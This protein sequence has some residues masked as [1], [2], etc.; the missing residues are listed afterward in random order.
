MTHE[1][2]DEGAE[3]DGGEDE[4]DVN[5]IEYDFINKVVRLKKKVSA[6]KRITS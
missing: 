1:D 2:S 4:I 3:N 6:V 5:E